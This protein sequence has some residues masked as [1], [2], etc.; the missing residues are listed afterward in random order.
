[1]N[2][3]IVG[4]DLHEGS[5]D[6]LSLGGALAK[7]LGARLLVAAA[8]EHAPL[9]IETLSQGGARREHLDRIFAGVDDHI[10]GV[11]Y[12]RI[13]LEHG[14]P[15]GL[16][17]LAEAESADLVVIGHT[18]RGSV[19][20]FVAGTTGDGLLE[21]APCAVA[22]APHDYGQRE[23]TGFGLIGVAYDGGPE[24]R[25]ALTQ[26][27]E[28]A[29]E[30]GCELRLI[31]I[32]PAFDDVPDPLGPARD[33]LYRERLAAGLRAVEKVKAS[34]QLERGDPARVLARLGVELDLLIVGSRSRGRALRTLMGSVASELIRTSPCPVIVTPRAAAKENEEGAS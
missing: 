12:E 33:T 22:V 19:G 13:E 24:S 23:H 17:E 25:L 9:P 28:L 7:T 21:G 2:T 20:R 18:H 5:H 27:T 31:G 30:L 8:V 29:A 6:A 34:S 11:E 4:V 26:A 1:M 15:R 3:I 10:R 14:A 32:A 16:E